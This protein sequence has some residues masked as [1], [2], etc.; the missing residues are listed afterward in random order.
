MGCPGTKAWS[1]FVGR[2]ASIIS[3]Y[4]IWI[5]NLRPEFKP[6]WR[7]LWRRNG[8]ANRIKTKKMKQND[9]SQS[10]MRALASQ[11]IECV[12]DGETR[13]LV[14][15]KMIED[16]IKMDR[17]PIGAK[18]DFD[19]DG[20]KRNGVVTSY[21]QCA[22]E[23]FEVTCDDVFPCEVFVLRSDMVQVLKNL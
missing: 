19:W 9:Q 22:E 15:A 11:I 21:D 12:I 4:R 23:H 7:R 14:I 3:A 18:V 6:F 17:P 5:L 20:A 10:M 13:P 1:G 16:G 8:Q 2:A